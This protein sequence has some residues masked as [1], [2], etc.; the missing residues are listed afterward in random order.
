MAAISSSI[1]ADLNTGNSVLKLIPYTA[2]GVDLSAQAGIDFSAADELFTLENSFTISKDAPSWNATR[3]DQKHKV[4][5]QDYTPGDNYVM[6]GNVPS[7]AVDLLSL[8][9]EATSASSV[10]AID[11]TA[12][13]TSTKAYKLGSKV[14]DYT[15]LA[16]SQSGANAL[17]FARVRFVFSEPQ[18]DDNTTPTYVHFEA[19]VLP[20]ENASGDFAPLPTRASA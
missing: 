20:N 8:A 12:S 13:Y 16:V 6:S 15:V 11:G 1:L 5:E 9:F 2:G 19:A 18:H 10:K 7:I 17:I 3:I 14:Q 4:I